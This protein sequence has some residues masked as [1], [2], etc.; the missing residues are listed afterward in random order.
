MICMEREGYFLLNQQKV[1]SGDII[2]IDGS[3][4]SIY[5]GPVRIKQDKT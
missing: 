4:G 3:E 5:L 1:N 2:S